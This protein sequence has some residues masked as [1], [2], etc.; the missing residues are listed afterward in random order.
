MESDD[1]AYRGLI[2]GSSSEES[3]EMSE[4][5]D[6]EG[7]SKR[8]QAK[9]DEMRRRLLGGISEDKP[10]KRGQQFEGEQFESDDEVSDGQKEELQVNF[11]VG[12]GEDIGQK[13]LSNKQERKEIERMGDF[14]KWQEKRKER[15]REKK[16]LAKEKASKSKKQ[17]KM[18]E[19]E[20]IEMSAEERR[21]RAE[22]DLLVDD[23]EHKARKGDAEGGKRDL[24][25]VTEG[26]NEFAVDPTHKEYRK[27]T[28]GHNK[29]SKRKRV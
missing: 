10:G 3:E 29:I 9:I 7:N 5:G 11:G 21:Q 1:D 14:Q 20:V 13:L 16:Q 18:S 23:E 12:F 28:Q 17:G 4:N 15:K 24:R 8:N 26:D 19:K 6:A 25:F 22:L 2:A 27:V